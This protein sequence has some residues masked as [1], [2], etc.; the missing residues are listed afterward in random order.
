MNIIGC[1]GFPASIHS[2]YKQLIG[3]LLTG[4][5]SSWSLQVSGGRR[6]GHRDM[7]GM[8]LYFLP[9]QI[10]HGGP[11]G[12]I[13]FF[14]VLVFLWCTREPI[15][16]PPT[17]WG[18]FFIFF[19]WTH[20]RMHHEFPVKAINNEIELIRL[21]SGGVVRIRV[22]WNA[23]DWIIKPVSSIERKW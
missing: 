20:M 16:G 13:C 18:A 19:K 5:S 17:F 3:I 4:K 21:W 7:R 8:D 11:S 2:L 22:C 1:T 6:H 23:S 14:F 10:A 9:N 15:S 12:C